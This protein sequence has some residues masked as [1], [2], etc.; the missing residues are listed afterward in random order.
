MADDSK[1]LRWLDVL[2]D[3]MGLVVGVMLL[4]VGLVTYRDGGSVGWFVAGVAVLLI[5][6]W[7]VGRRFRRR[8]KPTPVS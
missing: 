1:V 8:R 3:L 4:V 5:N 2:S 7:V 6:L